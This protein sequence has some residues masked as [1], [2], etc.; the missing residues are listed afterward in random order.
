MDSQHEGPQPLSTADY[1]PLGWLESFLKIGA[2]FVSTVTAV[3][4]PVIATQY[5]R[6][7]VPLDFIAK[8]AMFRAGLLPVCS[9]VAIAFLA[10]LY[11]PVPNQNRSSLR[12]AV[13]DA[14]RQ[15]R[16]LLISWL[17]MV[18]LVVVLLSMDALLQSWHSLWHIVGYLGRYYFAFPYSF[19]KVTGLLSIVSFV[20][21][22]VLT[23]WLVYT[24]ARGRISL[25]YMLAGRPHLWV[26]YVI[27]YSTIVLSYASLYPQ[28]PYWAGG[29]K[30]RTVTLWVEAKSFPQPE[31]GHCSSDGDLLLCGGLFLV[32][33]NSEIL[34]I[35]DGDLPS[36]P[37]I[38]PRRDVV[39]ALTSPEV[40]LVSPIPPLGD[41]S[42]G[43][44]PK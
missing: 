44:T 21:L 28:I 4:F 14:I 11:S 17:L 15:K 34:I 18:V 3:G 41:D 42:E 10:W 24:I 9:F 31:R 23:S 39:K 6:M 5:S 1:K 13:A 26:N 37:A 20:A 19:Q 2:I 29:G 25:E 33:E 43:K 32:Y 8:D 27:L 36:S 22:L 38:V 7:D 30:P 12:L 35:S 40:K 16:R